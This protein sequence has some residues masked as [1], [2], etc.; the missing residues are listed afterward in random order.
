MH[1]YAVTGFG[2]PSATPNLPPTALQACAAPPRTDPL[3][4]LPSLAKQQQPL[5]Q[6]ERGRVMGQLAP[7]A[8]G[9]RVHV[10]AA[11]DVPIAVYGRCAPCLHAYCLACAAGMSEC[12][13]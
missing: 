1:T 4:L 10:C 2:P 12:L 11:C 5:R 3:A 13:M 6:Q 7:S 9:R 8:R